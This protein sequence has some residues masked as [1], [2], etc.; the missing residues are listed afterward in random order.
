V[1]AIVAAG[2]VCSEMPPAR[3]AAQIMATSA[4]DPY[5]LGPAG[6]QGIAQFLPRVWTAH[7]E[8]AANRTPWEP[9]A[10]IRALGSTM[11]ALVKDSGGQYAPALAAFTRGDGAAAVPLAEVV[12]KSQAEY[13]KDSRL[14]TAKTPASSAPPS[15]APAKPAKPKPTAKKRH[16]PPVKAV[17]G[18]STTGYGPYFI[19]NLRTGQCADLPGSGPGPRDGLVQQYACNKTGEDNQEWTFMPRGKDAAGYQ[20]YWIRN[21]DDNY[22]IDA[23]G[24]GAVASSTELDETGCFDEGDNQYFRLEPKLTSDGFK[25]YWLRNTVADMCIDVPG[26]GTGGP[27]AR[28]ALVPCMAGDD[29][30]WALVEKSEW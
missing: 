25:Y 13:A 8:P 17:S 28:L 3:I 27:E 5:R 16:Q 4:F 10:A 9:A 24:V 7:V 30:E 22:C 11:C 23:P 20:L 6:E 18:N 2:K 12:T 15:S 19:L 1:S 21:D 26:A 14:Q 29:H